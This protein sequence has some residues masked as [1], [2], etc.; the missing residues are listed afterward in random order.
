MSVPTGRA[1]LEATLTDDLS[2]APIAWTVA[3]SRAWSLPDPRPRLCDFLDCLDIGVDDSNA[4]RCPRLIGSLAKVAKTRT[5][6]PCALRRER[7]AA[8]VRRT[9]D[10]LRTLPTGRPGAGFVCYSERWSRS[11]S[12]S[13]A[14]SWP[15]RVPTSDPTRSTMMERT[16]SACAFESRS[17]PVAVA[18]SPRRLSSGQDRRGGFHRDASAETHT[19]LHTPMLPK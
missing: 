12:S 17:S 5:E 19:Q 18:S 6:T 4:H 3:A 14:A 13:S 1:L 15:V 7:R 8:L 11:A 9:D 2:N 10:T 16:C